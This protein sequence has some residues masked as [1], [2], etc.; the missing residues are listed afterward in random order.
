MIHSQHKELK[1]E[2][3]KLYFERLY[4]ARKENNQYEIDYLNDMIAA[5]CID[6]AI[7]IA[8][9]YKLFG[10]TD[11][12][13]NQIALLGLTRA[14]N[15]Y[16]I[17]HKDGAEFSSYAYNCI[18]NELKKTYVLIRNKKKKEEIPFTYLNPVKNE[19]EELNFEN[20]IPDNFNMEEKIEGKLDSENLKNFI[21]KSKKLNNREK[22]FI[23]LRYGFEAS[24]T[25]EEIGEIHNI[26]R[27][28]AERVLKKAMEKIKD[29]I[30]KFN[31]NDKSF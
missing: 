15:S 7:G 23:F 26:T 17:N 29:S 25:L 12:E 3:V 28:R 22:K 27:Q 19:E 2:E 6:L 13:V 30:S 21:L 11:N 14:I 31:N 20:N 18:E 1:N 16:D 4:K 5:S 24:K 10:Y 8:N 9:S